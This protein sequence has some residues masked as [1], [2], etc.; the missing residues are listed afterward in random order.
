MNE[1]TLT[2][3]ANAGL[4]GPIVFGLTITIL[5]FLEYD[6]MIRLGW[7]PVQNSDVPWPSGLALGPYGWFQVANFVFLGL[8]VIAFAVG[9]HRGVRVSGRGS[10]VGPALLIVAGVGMLISGFKTDPSVSHPQT[11]HGWIHGLAFFVVAFLFLPAFFVLWRRLRRDPLWR[12]YDRYTL[13]S[14]VLYVSL[15]FIA[16]TGLFIPEQVAFY[17]FLAV[18]LVWIEVMAIR[19]RSI[20]KTKSAPVG[21][22]APVG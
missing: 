22:A 11:W 15:F 17:F 20:A 19:L 3:L 13:V 1:R 16:M 6:F 5:T 14:G 18:M 9:L 12:G 7:D 21:Q 8:T 4:I 2:R 10:W